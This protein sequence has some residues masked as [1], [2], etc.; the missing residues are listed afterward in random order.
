MVQKVPLGKEEEKR[1]IDYFTFHIKQLKTPSLEECSE[2]DF[3][4]ETFSSD[5]KNRSARSVQ[6]KVRSVITKSKSQVK[7]KQ[8]S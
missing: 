1:L 6:D 7:D 3:S 8:T 2:F 4:E 5:F